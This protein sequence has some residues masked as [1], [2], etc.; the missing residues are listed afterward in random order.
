MW[1]HLRVG[2]AAKRVTLFFQIGSKLSVVIDF[3]V[4]DDSD[5]AV[6]IEYRLFACNE[7]DNCEAA[8]A[9]CHAGGYEYSF[10]IRSAM[11]HALAHRV[12]K[13]FCAF[14]LARERVEVSPT[15]DAAHCR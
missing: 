13:F 6:F 12:Q 1:Q 11:D 4:Q 10:G 3:T 9:E 14:G 7:I 2:S 5:A 15:S 8:H